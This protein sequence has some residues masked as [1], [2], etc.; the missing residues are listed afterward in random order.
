MINCGIYPPLFKKMAR[1][2]KKNQFFKNKACNLSKKQL[3]SPRVHL[4]ECKNSSST[5]QVSEWSKEHDWKSCVR[6]KRTEGSNPS[7]SAKSLRVVA[8]RDFFSND[9]VRIINCHAGKNW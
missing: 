4:G 6:Q 5:G 9:E 2:Y 3:Y 1:I 7:L 8:L